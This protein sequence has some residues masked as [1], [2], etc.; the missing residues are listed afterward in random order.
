MSIIENLY[1]KYDDFCIDVPFWEIPDQ[2]VTVLWGPSGAGKTSV[3]RLLIG[4][5]R[6]DRPFSWKFHNTNVA[7]L[8]IPERHLGVVFQTWELFPHMTA[9]E[10]IKFAADSRGLSESDFRS[11]I[12]DFSLR[13]KMQSFLDRKASVLSG[14][15]KQRVALAR[16]MIVRPRILLLD[17]PFSSLDESLKNESRNLLKQF[18]NAED[19]PVLL[20][21]HDEQDV[22]ILADKM[23]TI[24]NGKIKI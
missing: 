5:E 20:V 14:G 7:E 17:E 3:F 1:K 15:E 10:N 2:G 8:P 23:S 21:T 6:A 18:L 9:L 16:A 13:L 11:R 4:V 22:Q 12:Q 19:V 24:E